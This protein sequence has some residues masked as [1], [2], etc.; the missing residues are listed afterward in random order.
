MKKTTLLSAAALTVLLPSLGFAQ[1]V[2]TTPTNA[3]IGFI[4]TTFMFLVAGFLV[5]FMAA[6]FAMHIDVLTS[7]GLLLVAHSSFDRMLGYGLKFPDDFKHTSLGW[8]GK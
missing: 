5:F 2:D 7:I 3:E 8:A 1:E 4:F 6:G